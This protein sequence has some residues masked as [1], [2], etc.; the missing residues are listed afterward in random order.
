MPEAPDGH[1]RRQHERLQLEGR[2]V[3]IADPRKGLIG[4]KG[5]LV[6][7]S[8]GGCQVRIRS[9]VGVGIAARVRLNVA[10]SV[11]WLPAVTRRARQDST[12][13]TLGCAFERLTPKKQ[14][15]LRT[16][17]FDLSI[18]RAEL[19]ANAGEGDA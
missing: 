12:G 5:Q 8:E 19:D 18:R 15:A 1:N 10:G 9:R 2:V 6:D 7:V 4:A 16:M 11:L 14:A 13:W 3:L 17:L